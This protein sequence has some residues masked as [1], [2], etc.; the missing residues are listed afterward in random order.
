MNFNL[1]YRYE[2][3]LFFDIAYI[4]HEEANIYQY[5]YLDAFAKMVVDDVG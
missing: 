2:I 4:S 1:V 3:K 5:L